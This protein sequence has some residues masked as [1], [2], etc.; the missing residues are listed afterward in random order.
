MVKTRKVGSSVL[1]ECSYYPNEEYYLLEMTHLVGAVNKVSSL[2]KEGVDTGGN[3]DSLKLTL[4]AGG[5]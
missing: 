5:A 1:P 4:L 2:A 3:D